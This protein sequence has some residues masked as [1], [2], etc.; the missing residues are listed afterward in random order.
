MI[1]IDIQLFGGRGASGTSL[2][3]ARNKFEG[4]SALDVQNEIGRTFNK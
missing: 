2:R 1:K 3:Q 4:H